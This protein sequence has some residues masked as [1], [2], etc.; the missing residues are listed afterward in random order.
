MCMNEKFWAEFCE[1]TGRAD[2]AVDPRFATLADR[3]RNLAAL[4][5]TLDALFEAQPTAHW[6][7]LFAGRVPFGPVN[8]LFEALDNPFVAEVGMRDI[9]DHPDRPQGLHMLAMPVKIDG[10]RMPGKRSPKLGEHT[11]ELLG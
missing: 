2:L 4:T 11:D 3:A 5:E 1:L 8:G 6:Q 7:T 10:D 9:V